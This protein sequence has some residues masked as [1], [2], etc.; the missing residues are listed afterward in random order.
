M[1]SWILFLIAFSLVFLYQKRDKLGFVLK[2]ARMRKGDYDGA[3]RWLRWTSVGS[4]SVFCLHQEGLILTMAGRLVESERRYRRSLAMTQKGSSYP[5]ERLYACL[6]FVLVDLG[7]YDEAE[8][9]FRNAIEAGDITGSS[10]D[11][12]AE[13]LLARGVEP[14]KALAYIDQGIEIAKRRNSGPVHWERSATRAWA[15]GLLGR[16]DKARES[17]A[18]ALGQPEIEAPFVADCHWRI[19]MALLAMQQTAEACHHFQLGK[20][21]DPRGKY[22]KRCAEMLRKSQ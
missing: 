1:R 6:G 19:G 15:L 17:I 20:D 3:L 8:Q 14:E 5:R 13:V 7:R 4:P 11:G 18:V 9:S 10:Q 22:G 21:A 2:R 16:S 12:F